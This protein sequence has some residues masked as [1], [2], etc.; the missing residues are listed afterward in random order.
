MKF[1]P[2][3]EQFEAAKEYAIYTYLDAINNTDVERYGIPSVHYFGLWDDYVLMAI[4]LL[5][6]NC[7]KKSK[8]GQLNEL[9]MIIIFREFVS[10]TKALPINRN[11]SKNE[12]KFV[13]DFKTGEN[14][15]IHSWPWRLSRG[16]Q[17][18]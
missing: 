6:A 7:M 3:D 15:E 4:T 17:I 11:Q 10:K 14:N 12:T 2:T 9:D 18:G 16:H 8:N 1:T 13:V 5:D